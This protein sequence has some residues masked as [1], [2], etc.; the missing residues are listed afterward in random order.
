MNI[1]FNSDF[2]FITGAEKSPPGKLKEVIDAVLPMMTA[3]KEGNRRPP[4]K[5]GSDYPKK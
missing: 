1:Y 5:P 2:M 4:S 3:L